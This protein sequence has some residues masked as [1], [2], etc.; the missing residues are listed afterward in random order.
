MCGVSLADR[1]SSREIL[2][3]CKLEDVEVVLK[4]KRLSWF[5][6]V[7]RRSEVDPLTRI[8]EVMVPGRRPRGRPKKTWHDCVRQ[9]LTDGEIPEHLTANRDEWRAV[10]NRLTSSIE[11]RSRR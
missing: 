2:E 6:H 4:K 7:K 5:G 9:D 11:G 3:R 1:I 10:V 8:Q